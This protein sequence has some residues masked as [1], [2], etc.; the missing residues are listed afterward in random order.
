MPPHTHTHTPSP[1]PCFSSSCHFLISQSSFKRFPPLLHR[2]VF[3]EYFT[4]VPL[5]FTISW[6]TD[7]LCPVPATAMPRGNKRLHQQW[8]RDVW[9]HGTNNWK[10][11]WEQVQGTATAKGVWRTHQ[12]ELG[13]DHVL[14]LHLTGV[15]NTGT[16]HTCSFQ[17]G[18]G[19]TAHS[20][21]TPLILYKCGVEFSVMMI[22]KIKLLPQLRWEFGHSG[23]RKHGCHST[24]PVQ[25]SSCSSNTLQQC[26]SLFYSHCFLRH[27]AALLDLLAV[28]FKK[29]K[30][31][32]SCWFHA[33]ER[34]RKG[35]MAV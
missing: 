20:W 7:R 30:G 13:A 23:N 2:H 12:R 26:H 9:K 10:A 3:D 11:F 4:S 32:D 15:E 25:L 8:H 6:S 31:S 33:T 17:A 27:I 19:N 24:L 18:I 1:P 28:H 16:S 29:Y 5:N 34:R 35:S 22:L 14:L 21:W